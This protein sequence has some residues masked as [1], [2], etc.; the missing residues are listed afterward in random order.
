MTGAVA[1]G[2]E[3]CRRACGGHGYLLASGVSLHFVSYLPQVT[4]EVRSIRLMSLL[5]KRP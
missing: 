3:K 1:D 5:L 2:I 4:Y